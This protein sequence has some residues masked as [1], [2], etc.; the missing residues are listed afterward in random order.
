MLII[1]ASMI[2]QL[3]GLAEGIAEGMCRTRIPWPAGDVVEAKAVSVKT[4]VQGTSWQLQCD[5]QLRGTRCITPRPWARAAF[6]WGTVD[7]GAEHWL[8]LPVQGTVQS[9]PL[10]R[11]QCLLWIALA[12][13]LAAG[14]ASYI[15]Q[16]WTGCSADYIASHSAGYGNEDGR[17]LRRSK[18]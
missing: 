12:K 18:C 16:Y 9:W 14:S 10:Y 13:V 6:L 11:L 5:G 4:E 1:A 2:L 15:A 3:E 8:L 17:S 7:P